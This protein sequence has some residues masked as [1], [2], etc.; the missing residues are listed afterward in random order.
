MSRLMRILNVLSRG[1]YNL[2]TGG[3]A[4]FDRRGSCAS[5]YVQGLA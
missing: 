2:H 4:G 1:L 5:E 3:P